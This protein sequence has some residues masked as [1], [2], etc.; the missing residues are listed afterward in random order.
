MEKFDSSSAV[1][2]V[3]IKKVYDQESY[4]K[5]LALNEEVYGLLH[6]EGEK[7]G[8]KVSAIINGIENKG[9][10]FTPAFVKRMKELLHANADDQAFELLD[11]F[12]YKIDKKEVLA[13]LF[14]DLLIEGGALNIEQAALVQTTFPEL[15]YEQLQRDAYVFKRLSLAPINYQ[16][17]IDEMEG[18]SPRVNGNAF[19]DP[20]PPVQPKFSRHYRGLKPFKDQSAQGAR[21]MYGMKEFDDWLKKKLEI[22]EKW[23]QRLLMNNEVQQDI[24]DALDQYDQRKQYLSESGQTNRI[25]A[26]LKN[27][28]EA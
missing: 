5:E 16:D 25:R 22:G 14:I 7:Y 4:E 23:V 6:D 19:N 1:E 9:V 11:D 21:E 3:D 18:R 27:F 15:D 2:R 8:Y 10:S 24:L 26:M 28:H 12:T 17:M 13:E 20:D